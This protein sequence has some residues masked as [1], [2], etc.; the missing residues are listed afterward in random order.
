[1]SKRIGLGLGKIEITETY[2]WC[3]YQ[4]ALFWILKTEKVH[5]PFIENRVSEIR[6]IVPPQ[7]WKYCPTDQNPADIASRGMKASILKESERWWEGPEFLKQFPEVWP[8]HQNFDNDVKDDSRPPDTVSGEFESS[9][10]EEISALKVDTQT[11]CDIHALLDVSRHSNIQKL[12]RIIGFAL[13]FVNNLRAK[14]AGKELMTGEL[15]TDE[16]KDH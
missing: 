16:T 8:S 12:L 14:V 11:N 7:L 13:R 6:K 5:K 3:D 15:I 4:I 9:E 1:M 2:C 10:F